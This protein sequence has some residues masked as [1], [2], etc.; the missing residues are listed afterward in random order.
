MQHFIKRYIDRGYS[1][2][3]TASREKKIL[4]VW[5]DF[6][7]RKPTEKEITA[8]LR[9]PIQ[10]YAIV[11]GEISNLV[12]FDVDTKNGGDPTPFLNRGL[13][14]IRTPSGGYHFY[15]LYDPLLKSTKHK[16]NLHKGIL[17]AVDVQS[18]GSIVFCPPTIFS[19]GKYIIENDVPITKLPDDLLIKV[20]EELQPEKESTDYT[21]YKGHSSPLLGRPGDV[22]NA[23]ATWE[24]VL[25]PHGW[26][27][28]GDGRTGVQYWKRPGKT[29]DGVSASTN[30]KGYDLFFCFTTSVPEITP[31]KGYTKFSLLT[32]LKYN[33]DFSRASKELVIENYKLLHNRI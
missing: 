8:W 20:L 9:S 6:Q 22:F 7:K 19:N 1:F 12:V 18:N 32:A 11:C 17:H 26:K 4:T 25:I 13:H 16:K 14:E 3:N 27:K 24:D 23:F 28:I 15:T 33:G 2:F 10:N 5:K 31:L 21:P 29:D 30:Y